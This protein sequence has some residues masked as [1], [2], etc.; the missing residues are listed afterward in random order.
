MSY[1]IQ[2]GE[3]VFSSP[4]SDLKLSILA[5]ATILLPSD[6]PILH[7]ETQ[8]LKGLLCAGSLWVLQAPELKMVISVVCTPDLDESTAHFASQLGDAIREAKIWSELGLSTLYKSCIQTLEHASPKFELSFGMQRRIDLTER[9]SARWVPK[10]LRNLGDFLPPPGVPTACI[11]SVDIHLKYD[12]TYRGGRGYGVSST[13]IGLLSEKLQGFEDLLQMIEFH[14]MNHDQIH[15]SLLS[16]PNVSAIPDMIFDGSF[17][18]LETEP[19]L[20]SSFFSQAWNLQ[21]LASLFQDGLR[22]LVLGQEKRRNDCNPPMPESLQ[23]LSGIAPVVF[24]PRHS[25]AMNQRGRLISS[26]AKSLASMM[27]LSNNLSFR[28]RLANTNG[29]HESDGEIPISPDTGDPKMFLQ[30][31]FWRIAQKR[32]YNTPIPKQ[33]NHRR[34]FLEWGENKQHKDGDML[35]EDSVERTD[36]IGDAYGDYDDCHPEFGLLTHPG[37]QPYETTLDGPEEYRFSMIFEESE[38]EKSAAMSITLLDAGIDQEVARSIAGGYAHEASTLA[39]SDSFEGGESARGTAIP[40]YY[41]EGPSSCEFSL[42]ILAERPDE[43]SGEMLLDEIMED[44][45]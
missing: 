28:E 35:L 43:G 20:E 6:S 32:L 11:T 8:R 36:C 37:D 40:G 16:I 19:G 26:I 7:W 38:A 22:T 10:I 9:A 14:N 31:K 18:I 29:S 2:L 17:Q 15:P 5:S 44:C 21:D 33:L 13:E 1:T 30:T 42:R 12:R 34:I 45:P 4:V 41:G 25:E 23:S 24:K 3:S 39:L 27:K